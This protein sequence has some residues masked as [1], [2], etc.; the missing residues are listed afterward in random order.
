M[1]RFLAAVVLCV[2]LPF[3]IEAKLKSYAPE[4]SPTRA[5]QDL[6]DMLDA[7]VLRPK[8]A[9][10]RRFNADLKKKILH[11]TFDIRELSRVALDKHWKDLKE[12]Q[13]E[14]FVDLLT[15]LLER[16]AIFSKEQ[17]SQKSGSKNVYS[18]VYEGDRLLDGK[19]VRSLVLTSVRIP[20]ENLKIGLNYKMT[21]VGG[22]WKI[23]DVIVDDASLA[24]NY[25]YQFDRIIS[26]HGYDDLVHRMESKLKELEEKE[27][28]PP[29]PPPPK[30]WG[31]SLDRPS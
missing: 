9:E 28:L 7:Y 5:I 14:G 12:S 17:G 11:G 24:D 26:Q 25:K 19:K 2:A 29:P 18:V 1:N 4:G 3:A 8:T 16:K 20:S 23:Y 27:G 21:S 15:R 31:C 30:K 13:R 10:E 6:D 22:I